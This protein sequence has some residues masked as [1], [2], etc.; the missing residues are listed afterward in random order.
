M[1]ATAIPAISTA[2]AGAT[3][4]S[5][6]A[7]LFAGTATTTASASTT[8]GCGTGPAT[9]RNPS[10]VRVSSRTGNP[11]RTV[12]NGCLARVRASRARPPRRVAKTG[13]SEGGAAARAALAAAITE[14]CSL[15]CA[16]NAGIVAWTDNSSVRPAYTPPSSG[17]TRRSR[18]SGPSRSPMS[19]PTATSSVTGVPGSLRSRATAAKPAGLSRLESRSASRSAGTPSSVPAGTG[20]SVPFTAIAALV[21]AG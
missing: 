18:S 8:V 21:V 20:R 7:A 14:A 6:D 17:S 5:N 3:E 13:P 11:V 10:A 19:V 4:A 12:I 2:A 15:S 9:S 1:L 16:A